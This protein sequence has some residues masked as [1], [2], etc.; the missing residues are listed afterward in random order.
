M[1]AVS[2]P[3]CDPTLVARQS[4]ARELARV[5]ESAVLTHR[6]LRK[7]SIDLLLILLL[8]LTLKNMLSEVDGP[9]GICALL[10]MA[11]KMAFTLGLHREP[12][13]FQSLPVEQVERRRQVWAMVRIFNREYS[14]QSGHPQTI[15]DDEC[16]CQLPTTIAPHVSSP[17]ST[18]EEEFTLAWFV[19]L[20]RLTVL[21]AKLEPR[22]SSMRRDLSPENLQAY[23]NG[24][25]SEMRE[26][27]L[28]LGLEIS[29]LTQLWISSGMSPILAFY[30]L[31][32]LLWHRTTMILYQ[33][34]LSRTPDQPHLAW[35]PYVKAALALLHSYHD[36]ASTQEDK[37]NTWWYFYHSH[38]KYHIYRAVIGLCYAVCRMTQDALPPARTRRPQQPDQDDD[39]GQQQPA[40]PMIPAMQYTPSNDN[41]DSQGIMRVVSRTRDLWETNIS[42]GINYLKAF[43]LLSMVIARTTAVLQLEG[44]QA[45]TILE[46][47]R[48]LRRARE[49]AETE[50]TPDDM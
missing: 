31:L 6:G 44:T 17:G 40:K 3:S 28:V 48:S 37:Q 41:P 20:A 38:I 14:V 15:R 16:D 23:C 25:A 13:G 4:N 46:A 8:L 1:T 27:K 26:V 34:L 12:R 50:L 36:F 7:P 21:C 45:A 11:Q 30:H 24:I 47:E 18:R 32:H 29:H 42:G 9:D 10:G 49:I 22:F 39:I 43:Q 5:V 33:P 2:V 19:S 35:P